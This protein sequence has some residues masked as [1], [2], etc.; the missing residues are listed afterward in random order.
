M[1]VFKWFKIRFCCLGLFPDPFLSISDSI[2]R[3]LGLPNRGFRME[4]IATNRLFM[5][6]VFTEFLYGLLSFFEALGTVFL[7]FLALKTDL[8]TE[9][10]L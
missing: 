6:I 9:G 4:G 5:E 3:C 7:I 1:S 2:F 8:K 10:F